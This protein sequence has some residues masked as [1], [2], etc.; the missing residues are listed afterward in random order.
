MLVASL[1]SMNNLSAPLADVCSPDNCLLEAEIA[2][3]FAE[4]VTSSRAWSPG[5]EVRC[6]AF[7][8]ETCINW[9]PDTI[10]NFMTSPSSA[11]SK[12]PSEDVLASGEPLCP[13]GDFPVIFGGWLSSNDSEEEDGRVFTACTKH[14]VDCRVSYGTVNIE[15]QYF[16][17]KLFRSSFIKFST[18]ISEQ[19]SLASLWQHG[20]L[21][22]GGRKYSPYTL[23]Y[24]QSD[25]NAMAP[26]SR[27]LVPL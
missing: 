8:N 22:Y 15:Y 6:S 5:V 19:G 16:G 23:A 9:I 24:T 7:G 11:C 18:P 13:P 14:T 12:R 3:L 25:F 20:F 4:C 21:G 10:L 27:Y 1:A 2:A 26:L 17:P